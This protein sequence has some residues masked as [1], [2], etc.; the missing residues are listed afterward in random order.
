MTNTERELDTLC[1]NAIRALSIDAVQRANSGHPGLPMGGA[2]MAYTLFQ[3]HLRHNPAN[4]GWADRD[5]F[6]LSAGH[7]SMLLYALLHLTGYPVSMDDLANFRQWGGLTA[8]HPEYGVAPGVEATTGPLGQGTANAVG[9]AMAE[10]ALAHR[11]NRPGHDIV[12]HFTFALAGDGDLMEGISAEAASLAGHLRLGKL[13]MLYD[14]N[15]ISL[16]GP[17]S[18]AF[19]ENVAQRY[20]AYGWQTITVADGDHDL[21]AIDRAIAEAKADTTRPTLIIVK[22]T[23][24]YGSKK[25]AGTSAAHG[26]PLGEEEAAATKANLG[27]T[28]APFTLPDQALDR[29]R[30]ALT[31]GKQWEDDWNARFEAYAEA[32]PELAEEWR[33]AQTGDL[34]DD[35]DS[36]LP[37]WEPGQKVATRASS[38][39][40]LN[41]FAAK[42][43]WLIGGDADLSCSTKTSI[44]DGGAFD[45]QTG[46][47]RNIHFGVREHAM[48]AI[49]NGMAYHKGLIPY[50]ATF[51]CFSD[52]MRPAI[53]L[54]A[55]SHLHVIF[56]FTHDSIGVGEDGPTH[57]PVEH[58][59]SL[60]AVPNLRVF[61]PGDATE[62]EEAWRAALQHKSGPSLLVL[63]RQGLPTFDRSTLAP[64]S[65]ARKGGYILSEA[66]GG[67]PRVIL[68][69]TGSETPLALD[70][71]RALEDRGA[72]TRVVSLPC[73]ELFAQQ[74]REYR[75]QVLP[76]AV[77]ARVGIE[78]GVSL[79][80]E[81]WVG[82]D[83]VVIA[84]DRFGAS[85]P[86]GTVMKEYGFT[87]ENIRDTALSLI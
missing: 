76:K 74:P 58:V 19:T 27:W 1:I 48:G 50:T 82:E 38:G 36:A 30:Q 28:H 25:V 29:F 61:R 23:I 55:L 9:M 15:D 72:P 84:V 51:L 68:I 4:P 59:A 75:E 56:V 11:Y 5:R 37:A 49:A 18:L 2:P 10:R 31:R 81:R 77:R 42:I 80:W 79:G 21:D 20:D 14:S 63:S 54:A 40:I 24:G 66:S 26:A 13:I 71:Q 52:Y 65:E 7:G 86:G 62:T 39:K 43:P 46:A 67:Q 45:G 87:V 12:D 57:Q 44:V 53:R 16:D 34:P 47:G 32:H 41:G 8:G 60:R 35:Y 83:G 70:A 3:R 85:A 78:A 17:T 22:T 33:R 73:W 69:A 6:V 64:Q